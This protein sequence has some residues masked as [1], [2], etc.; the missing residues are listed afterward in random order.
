MR[1]LVTKSN[2]IA[3][4]APVRFL[5]TQQSPTLVENQDNPSLSVTAQER[6][7]KKKETKGGF[8]HIF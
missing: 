3:S 5:I 1:T 4:S 8:G 7:Q 6:R 2:V